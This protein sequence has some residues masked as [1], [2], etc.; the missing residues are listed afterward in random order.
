MFIVGGKDIFGVLLGCET[1]MRD[2]RK[3]KMLWKE[4]EKR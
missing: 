2:R 4:R 1:Y 3:Y